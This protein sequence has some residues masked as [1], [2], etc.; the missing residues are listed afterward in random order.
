MTGDLLSDEDDRIVELEYKGRL[1]VA[2]GRTVVDYEVRA[3]DELVV[4]IDGTSVGLLHDGPTLSAEH[5]TLVDYLD[6]LGL[7]ISSVHTQ[8]DDGTDP[9]DAVDVTPADVDIDLEPEKANMKSIR[10]K[11]L[12]R[13]MSTIVTCTPESFD[14]P[15]ERETA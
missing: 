13:Q 7:R 6:H 4:T 9:G 5:E 8:L 14:L 2:D 11:W 12:R 3:V 10:R 1:L 15:V